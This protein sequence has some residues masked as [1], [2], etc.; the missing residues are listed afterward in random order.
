MRI[1][2]I[3][4]IAA[5]IAVAA[6][7]Q[8]KHAVYAAGQYKKL[9]VVAVIVDTDGVSPA[10][11]ERP[12]GPFLL[13]VENRL[14]DR[15]GHFSVGVDQEGSSELVGM[16]TKDKQVSSSTLIDLQPGSYRLRFTPKAN[17][18]VSIHVSK[19]K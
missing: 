19:A 10:S 16:D 4:L 14:P 2:R 13:Y 3:A 8:L 17:L 11:I 7:G 6:H 1:H 9:P 5:F 12:E 18:S 15:T